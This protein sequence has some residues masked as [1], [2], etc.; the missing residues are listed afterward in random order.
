[1]PEFAPGIPRK[2]ASHPFPKVKEPR[3]FEFGLHHHFSEGAAKEHFDLRI[4]DTATGHAH[5]WAMKYWP[6]PGEARLAVQQ[7]THTIPYMDFK[8]RIE[9]GYGKGRVELARREKTE[10][11]SSSHDH[12]QFNLYTGKASEEFLLRKTD[13]K[14][15][16]LHNITATRKEELPSSKPGYKTVDVGKLDLE[17]P[18]TVLQAKIDGAHVL[19][20]FKKPGSTMDVMSYRP[21]E[22]ATGVIEHTHKLPNFHQHKTPSAL[23]DTLLRGELYATDSSGKALAAARVGGLLNAGVWKS[24][25]K[26]KEEGKL[27]PA[28]FDVVKWKGKD[29]EEAPYSQKLEMLRE[30]VRHAPWLHIPR[31]AETPEE[32]KKLI[33]DVRDGKEPSTEEG[34]VEWHLEKHLPRKSKFLRENDAYVK[35]VFMEQGVRKGLAGGFSFS[36]TPDGPVVG[37]VG[38]GFSHELKRDMAQNPEKY[39]GLHARIATQPAPSHYAPRAPAFRSWHL[40]QDL[41]ENIKMSSFGAALC[42]IIEGE[43]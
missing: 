16:L 18:Q 9:S 7:P 32:K 41:P 28:V 2:E 35:D 30:A 17:D 22:R 14:Q 13:G 24:R 8:G 34:V 4:G 33:A 12:V 42:S 25:E 15:W 20:D 1:M 43:R 40:D 3:T 39:K 6:K 37:R 10:V 38:T 26:Q 31:T 36:R 27:L 11:V 21:T 29:V 5:S 19:Y 23:K